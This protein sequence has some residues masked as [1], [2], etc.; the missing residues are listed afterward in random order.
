[1]PML[2]KIASPRPDSAL[3]SYG[4]ED[5]GNSDKVQAAIR[6][7]HLMQKELTGMSPDQRYTLKKRDAAIKLLE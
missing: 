3:L 1:M 7:A 5:S 4:V 2:T 6:E